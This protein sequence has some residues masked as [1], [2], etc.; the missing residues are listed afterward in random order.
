MIQ[1]QAQSVGVPG[2]TAEIFFRV[3]SLKKGILTEESKLPFGL[4]HALD[5]ALTL[6]ADLPAVV[7]FG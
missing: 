5:L 1:R 6:G 2:R 3:A 7:L 4:R